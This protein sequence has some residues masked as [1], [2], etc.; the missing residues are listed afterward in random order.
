M[1]R[2]MY[3]IQKKGFRFL[4]I[5]TICLSL[6]PTSIIQTQLPNDQTDTTV[7]KLNGIKKYFDCVPRLMQSSDVSTNLKL[8]KS[9][10]IPQRPLT[11]AIGSQ[12]GTGGENYNVYDSFNWTGSESISTNNSLKSGSWGY[13]PTERET[14][15]TIIDPSNFDKEY[16]Y[17]NISNIVAEN[18]W[19]MIDDHN[20]TFSEIKNSQ[21]ADFDVT[22]G[23]RWL[24]IAISFEVKEP[25][26]NV[27]SIQTFTGNGGGG[28]PTGEIWIEGYDSGND[29]PDG[30]VLSDVKS[31]SASGTG[32][33]KY[34]IT[35]I[36][37][38]KGV[39]SPDRVNLDARSHGG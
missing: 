17:F 20:D 4:I 27:S 21:D 29:E 14:R 33:N 8:E 38:S 18:D 7:T 10:K 12:N 25:N 5:S 24:T 39:H 9:L 28:V 11:L 6:I 3:L 16:M 22:N 35:P 31:L 26:V 13:I 23:D 2:Q 37:L 15:F 36:K 34:D 30:N 1:N 19:R 32:W